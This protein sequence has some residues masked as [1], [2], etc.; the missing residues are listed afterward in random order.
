[1]TSSSFYHADRSRARQREV[2]KFRDGQKVSRSRHHLKVE[3]NELWRDS[4]P[5]RRRSAR[6]VTFLMGTYEEKRSDGKV[7]AQRAVL[8]MSSVPFSSVT[9]VS[10]SSSPGEISRCRR[11]GWM[12]PRALPN[13]RS[14]QVWRFVISVSATG[15]GPESR[16]NAGYENELRRLDARTRA[17]RTGPDAN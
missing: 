10:S 2:E 14:L 15:E 8:L 12:A 4:P 1:M 17:R 16:E 11:E 5:W 3:M 9:A 7:F 13:R 6:C